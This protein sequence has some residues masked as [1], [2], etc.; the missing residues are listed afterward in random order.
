[1]VLKVYQ[2][3]ERVKLQNHV[4]GELCFPLFVIKSVEMHVK[5]CMHL[6]SYLDLVWFVVV[7][8]S[9]IVVLH[10]PSALP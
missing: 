5:I 1:M 7:P 4:M 10:E 3:C 2:P 6:M 8:C 9:Y